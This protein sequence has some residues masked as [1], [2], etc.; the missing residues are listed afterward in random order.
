MSE[1][2]RR[3]KFPDGEM[4]YTNAREGGPLNAAPIVYWTDKATGK[5]LMFKLSGFPD[6]VNR[7]DIPEICNDLYK[8]MKN[9]EFLIFKN[10]VK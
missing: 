4:Y 9:K 5:K 7:E 8:R 1:D 2:F 3:V 10:Q 6:G